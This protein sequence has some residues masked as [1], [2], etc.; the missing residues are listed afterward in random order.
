MSTADSS[1][2]KKL[3]KRRMIE[4]EV[5]FR[6][7]NESVKEFVKGDKSISSDVIQPFYCECSRPTCTERIMLSPEKYEQLHKNKRLFITIPGHEFTEVEKVVN[8]K[9]NYQVVEKHDL[10]PSHRAINLA[11]KSIKV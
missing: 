9:N 7:V 8:V 2:R 1:P 6:R 10:P 4:N 3:S 5:I 11:L